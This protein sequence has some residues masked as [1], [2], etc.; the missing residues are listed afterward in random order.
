M[1]AV[2][3]GVWLLGGTMAAQTASAQPLPQPGDSPAN[4]RHESRPTSAARRGI[5]VIDLTASTEDPDATQVMAFR[6]E[7][8]EGGS[9][10]ACTL[11]DEP[12][13][14]APAPRMRT[15]APPPGRR[16][17]A[18]DQLSALVACAVD[19]QAPID[20]RADAARRVL[21]VA[22]ASRAERSLRVFTTTGDAVQVIVVD[23]V[24]LFAH[25]G[26]T[27]VARG[28]E[29]DVVFTEKARSMQIVSDLRSLA[30]LATE[31][32]RAHV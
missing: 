26:H 11:G 4:M 19:D 28:A 24:S 21:A 31:I 22:R 30:R 3:C 32:G 8:V 9:Q 16:G 5:V 7:Q 6:A 15:A 14:D 17:D 12:G 10:P 13:A 18:L 25:E 23:G 27:F 2:L 29:P 1:G 20:Q